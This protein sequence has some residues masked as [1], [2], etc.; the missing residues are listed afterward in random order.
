MQDY[1]FDHK[2]ETIISKKEQPYYIFTSDIHGNHNTIPL[3]EHA[4]SDFKS[5]QLVGGGDY[6]DGRKYS[7]EVCD[8]LWD[9]KKKNN[10]VI[11]KG[12]HEIMMTDFSAGKDVPQYSDGFEYEPLWLMNGG[13]ATI[14]SFLNYG[15]SKHK[16]AAAIP[17]LR[18]TKYYSDFKSAPIMYETPHF[19]FCHAGIHPT[20]DYNQRNKYPAKFDPANDN[21]NF[22]RTWAR[23]EYWNEYQPV[24]VIN[25]VNTEFKIRNNKLYQAVVAHNHTGKTIITGHTPTALIHAIYD[26]SDSK[27]R[28][29]KELPFTKCIV[30]VMQY[31]GEPAR[32]F[33]DNGC[34]SRYPKHDGNVTVINSDGN[35][36]AVYDYNHPTGIA[37]NEYVTE[38]KSDNIFGVTDNNMFRM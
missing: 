37:W 35:I 8:F 7:K 19:I 6:I 34:H 14:R 1:K 27:H 36:V 24:T 32:I 10:A 28:K 21:Y 30:R 26:K 29:I 17:L 2:T 9:Q 5:A 16:Y 11:L 33:T 3:I 18:Q 25:H 31:E 22:Y 23:K 38:N 20:A 13:K 12:N 4:M 15:F